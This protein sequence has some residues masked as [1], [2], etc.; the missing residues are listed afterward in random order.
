MDTRLDAGAGTSGYWFSYDDDGDGGDSKLVWGGE[1]GNETSPY[2]LENIVIA[3]NGV[4]GTAE[5]RKGILTYNP[6]MGIGFY[7]A[8]DDP[9]A[10]EPAAADASAWGGVCITYKSSIR[11]SLEMGLGDF[12]AVIGFANPSIQLDAATNEAAV[13]RIA[14]ADFKQPAWYKGT[15][16]IDGPTAAKQLV[17]I[18]FKMQGLPG[19]YDFNVCAIG[20]Y[21]GDCPSSCD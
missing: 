5:L 15:T 7:V 17:S 9:V 11:P 10:L 18:K 6:F 14:W 12:N 2:S 21:D 8:G 1:M 19:S 13:K 20:P 3:C 16:K 4:C